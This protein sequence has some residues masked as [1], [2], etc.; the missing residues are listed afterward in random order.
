MTT[1]LYGIKQCDT[2]RKARRWLDD[3]GIEY[4][5]HD[6]RE[7]GLDVDQIRAWLKSSD[8]ESLLNRRS[9]SWRQLSKAQQTDLDEDKAVQLMLQ[10]PTLIK[11]P[12]LVSDGA[13]LIGFKADSYTREFG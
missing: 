12:V 9:T 8:W 11:R 7:D 3:A 4:R 13:L 6:L 10:Y 1:I 2:V 5:F